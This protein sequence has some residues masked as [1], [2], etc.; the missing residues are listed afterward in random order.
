[1]GSQLEV[2]T[3]GSQPECHPELDVTFDGANAAVEKLVRVG[4]VLQL[5]AVQGLAA[6]A[7][8]RSRAEPPRSPVPQ[9]A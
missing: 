2:D 5:Q 8:L 6:T 3:H 7:R 9:A 1:M 4:L